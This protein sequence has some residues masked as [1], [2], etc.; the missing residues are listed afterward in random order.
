MRTAIGKGDTALPSIARKAAVLVPNVMTLSAVI[1][2]LTAIRLSQEGRAGW[3]TAAIFLAALLDF[4]DGFTA[5][6]LSATSPMGAELDTLADF[7]NF[8]VAP[9]LLLFD[10]ELQQFGNLGWAIAALYVLAA[11][12][13]LARFNV[14]LKAAPNTSVKKDFQGIPSPAAAAGVLLCGMIAHATCPPPL[15]PLLAAVALLAAS[16]LMISQLRIP[17]LATLALHIQNKLR[18]DDH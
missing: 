4:A 1:C 12:F 8:G 18:P 15:A 7:L 9:A 6:K 5:R 2:G 10:R 14:G 11:G 13:R 16:I 17:T 3:A